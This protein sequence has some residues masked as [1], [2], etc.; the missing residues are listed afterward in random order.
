MDRKQI[1]LRENWKF[2]LEEEME[3]EHSRDFHTGSP[4][5]EGYLRSAAAGAWYKGFDDSGWR[6]VTVPHDW[7]V[8]QPFSK[9][10]SSGTG[11]LAGGTGWYR[12]H[13]R[14]PESCRGKSLRVVFDGVYKN[15]QV[16]CNSY[17]LGQRPYGYSTFSYDITHAAAF[18][19]E[20]NVLSVKVVHT[21]LAD[22]RWFTGSG[23]T[24]KVTVL[25]EEPVHPTEYGVL[26]RAEQV[27]PDETDPG[28]RF[29]RAR[30]VVR[31]RTDVA[32]GLSGTYDPVRIRTALIDAEGKAVLI[33]EDV[34]GT[35]GECTLSG[36][37]EQARLWSPEHPYLYTLRTW[38][39]A[40]GVRP[41][42][43]E[44]SEEAFYLA[45]ET[46]VGIRG[47]AFNPDRGFFLN[48]AETKL[49]GVC[50]HH[51]GGA[52]G[53][54][55]E[56]E[57]WQ[58]RLEALREC[59]CNAIR[60]S[61]NPHMPELY[62]L[63]DRMGFLVMDEAF[64]EWENAKNKW[65]TG[66]NVYPPVHEGYFEAFPA[67][68][69]ADLRAMVRRDRNHP[70]VVLWS[71]GN[72]IDYPNDPY[73]HPSFAS[74]TGNNDAHKPAA[75]RQYDPGKPNAMR[76]VSIA[77]KLERIVREEDDTRPVTLAA[78]FPELSAET[79]LFRGLDV[80][81]YNYKEHLYAK[82]H[83][84][85]P[86]K[87]F[88]GSENGH[89][90]GAWLAVRDCPYIS[91]QFL[92]TGIDYLGE[93]RGW[94]VHGS[95]AGILTC[96]GDRKP[97]FYRRKSFWQKAPVLAIATRRASEGGEDWLPMESHWNYEPGEEILVKVY[98]NLPKVRLM[99][100]A[101]EAGEQGGMAGLPVSA[102]EG[103]EA[104]E[105]HAEAAGAVQRASGERR[106]ARQAG[107][108]ALQDTAPGSGQGAESLY[109]EEIGV[110]EGYN[111]DGAYCFRVSYRPGTL[112][113]FG[114]GA[115]EGAARASLSQDCR[116][117]AESVG[118]GR[119]T[120]NESE[121]DMARASGAD[122]AASCSLST[123]GCAA[124][125]DCAVWRQPDALTGR[126]WEEA[127]GEPG[128]LYQMEIG[129]RDEKGRPVSWQER[130]L[131]V[132][133]EGA[134]ALAGLESG[135]LADVT[136]Y[137]QNSRTTFRGRLLA[138]VRR[139]GQ[140]EIVVKIAMKEGGACISRIL[141]G[142]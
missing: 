14:L 98:S 104:G 44:L 129:L 93:A 95:P 113:A 12:V 42:E 24:R 120:D 10:Y 49:K 137:S 51:D 56:P 61:H 46:R 5:Q 116:K 6:S 37:L 47:I 84:R 141:P 36:T 9:R 25:V 110:L 90:Y 16:W 40:E 18:G 140:G 50:V 39:R 117:D 58:R 65:S 19:D 68:H 77:D 53:A 72:E 15:S 11:Y 112:T 38:Y 63:C 20:E 89:G 2:H 83:G 87:P 106:G 91:G 71:I 3:E 7:S 92:W 66:H 118:L 35:D 64:D 57:V 122:A 52:L 29:G 115:P 121:P 119:P 99:L 124:G 17:Y 94:P 132:T 62:D 32:E 126:G 13:F 27:E 109:R 123:V 138:F 43:E 8:E 45:D 100:E 81:G 136:P 131:T 133:V 34:T 97:E 125:L 107:T 31:H 75:E 21:D 1:V 127:S 82:D 41:A 55:M 105:P 111:G 74:M 59:G 101:W 22:S 23:I 60:C 67:W 70:S 96:A 73:C 4:G 103:T 128:Y 76:L 142:A 88:L 134:G 102:A 78:A 130:L 80:V 135:N 139:S 86:E 33:M 69:E 108:A 54:A 28:R 79:G 85:F 26:F 114:Y 30:I 48:G